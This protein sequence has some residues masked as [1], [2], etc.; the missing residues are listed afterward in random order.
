MIPLPVL[1]SLPIRPTSPSVSEA[2][3]K[4]KVVSPKNPIARLKHIPGGVRATL[5][6]WASALLFLA[7]GALIHKELAWIIFVAAAVVLGLLG[8]AAWYEAEEP[9]PKPEPKRS[10]VIAGEGRS[11][12]IYRAQA[13]PPS[14]ED[15]GSWIQKQED[16][17][18]ELLQ[19]IAHHREQL[20]L[21]GGTPGRAVPFGPHVPL[22]TLTQVIRKWNDE[23]RIMFNLTRSTELMAA[24]AGNPPPIPSSPTT[25]DC[26]NLS[27]YVQY[28]IETL[29]E[30]RLALDTS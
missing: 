21:I 15:L 1:A 25:E 30:A 18:H 3:D 16:R 27:F 17:G 22:I 12:A 7:A 20:L 6:S 28:R 11:R 13:L 29:R 8:L 2:V 4:L 10:T 23:L 24:C 19:T 26:D 9:K 14:N 5:V